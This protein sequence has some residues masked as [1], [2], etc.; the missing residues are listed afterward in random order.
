V[1]NRGKSLE[2]NREVKREKKVEKGGIATSAGVG[3]EERG[4]P[5]GGS[6]HP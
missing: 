6:P 2:L 4:C 1:N 3:E 5:E